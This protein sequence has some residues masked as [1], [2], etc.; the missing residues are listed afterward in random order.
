M[1]R[2]E[3]FKRAKIIRAISDLLGPG[4][5]GIPLLGFDANV[6]PVRVRFSGFLS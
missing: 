2:T 6:L 1:T 4:G 3:R 5:G